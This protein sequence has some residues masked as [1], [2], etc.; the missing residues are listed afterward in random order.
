MTDFIQRDG[1]AI[2]VYLLLNGEA[3]VILPLPDSSMPF[4][5]VASTGKLSHGFLFFD[6]PIHT[7]YSLGSSTSPALPAPSP[8]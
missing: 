8:V 1:N 7:E 5:E 4:L 2:I 6:M 3:H